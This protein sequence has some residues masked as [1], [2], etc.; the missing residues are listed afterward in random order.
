MRGHKRSILLAL[1][2]CCIGVV[3][4]AGIY[5]RESRRDTTYEDLVKLEEGQEEDTYIPGEEEVSALIRATGLA[6]D[7]EAD[8]S[9]DASAEDSAQGT[10]EDGSASDTDRNADKN[11]EPV[12]FADSESIAQQEAAAYAREEAMP[13]E[14]ALS[15]TVTSDLDFQ[16]DSVLTWP[17]QGEILMEFSLEQPVYFATLEQY[18][19]NP[20]LLIQ[21]EEGDMVYAGADGCVTAV[22]QNEELGNTVTLDLG[23]GYTAVYGQLKSLNVAEGDM[24][25]TGSALGLVAAPTGYYC[26]EGDHVYLQ[27]DKD[28]TPLDPLDYLD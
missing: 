4:M 1:L 9:T 24:V 11:G 5:R 16:A 12:P 17:V 6:G 27:L 20:G 14:E 28:G 2:L 8:A 13:A 18:K 26:V 3:T 25:S 7:E 15:G 22:G 19:P 23:N 10:E 21:A